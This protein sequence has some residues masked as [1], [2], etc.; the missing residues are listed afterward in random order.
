MKVI[1]RIADS[2]KRQVVSLDEFQFGF[3]PGRVITGAW[4]P[5]EISHL[6]L[7]EIHMF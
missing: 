6:A 4:T 7:W 1:E 2:L 5:L 3:V